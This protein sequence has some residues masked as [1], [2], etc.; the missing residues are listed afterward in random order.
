[1]GRKCKFFLRCSAEK[2]CIAFTTCTCRVCPNQIDV[3]YAVVCNAY[4]MEVWGCGVVSLCRCP[5]VRRLEVGRMAERPAR[6]FGGGRECVN[7]LCIRSS[8]KRTSCIFLSHLSCF[9]FH[10]T[11]HLRSYSHT[12]QFEY[13]IIRPHFSYRNIS[14]DSNLKRGCCW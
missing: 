6:T 2:T 10:L 5:F 8:L 12:H 13:P 9:S 14:F 3:E 4:A 11:I 1:M 7:I